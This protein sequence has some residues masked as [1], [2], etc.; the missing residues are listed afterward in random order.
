MQ[1]ADPPPAVQLCKPACFDSEG[2]D[3]L[4]VF[5]WSEF[6]APRTVA[7]AI[8]DSGLDRQQR[9]LPGGS[10]NKLA[11]HSRNQQHYYMELDEKMLQLLG[12]RNHVYHVTLTF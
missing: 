11:L 6:S 8:Q 3:G 10:S 1:P 12:N 7:A 4:N 9:R 2:A 5:Y